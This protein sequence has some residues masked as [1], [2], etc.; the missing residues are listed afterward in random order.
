MLACVQ[1]RSMHPLLQCSLA[2]VDTTGGSLGLDRRTAPQLKS[3]FAEVRNFRDHRK[4]MGRVSRVEPRRFKYSPFSWR[5]QLRDAHFSE[6][7]VMSRRNLRMTLDPL[8]AGEIIVLRDECDK[9]FTYETRRSKRA[10][11]Q[12]LTGV[13]LITSTVQI[14]FKS[15]VNPWL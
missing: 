7:R 15:D 2:G 1:E 5:V 9:E 12:L 11:S 10:T 8:A 4:K 14:F 6:M 13:L 3:K